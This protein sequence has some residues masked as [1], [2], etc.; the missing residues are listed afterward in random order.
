MLVVELLFVLNVLAANC[1]GGTRNSRA[2]GNQC[3]TIEGI[4]SPMECAEGH[5]LDEAANA[6]RAPPSFQC[7]VDK[8]V[9]IG[10]AQA[11]TQCKQGFAP[12]DGVCTA[13]GDDLVTKTAKCT[14][15]GGAAIEGTDTSCGKCGGDGYFL[16][17]GGCYK[18][19]ASPGELICTNAVGGVCAACK[20]DGSVFQNKASVKTPGSECILCSDSVGADSNKGVAN[21]AACDAPTG[22]TGTAKCKACAEGHALDEAANACRAPPSFQCEVD[23]LVTI[24]SAQACTQCKQ[25][26]APID[27]VCTA[28]GD[29]LVTKTAKCT[30]SGGAAIEGT[31][32]SCGKCGGDGYFLFMGGCYKT[33]ASPGELICTNAVG[34]VCAACKADGSVFQNKASV[35]TPG[36][37]CI[38]CSDSVG[39]DSNKG[40]A[41]CA[42]CDAPTGDTG[43]AKCKACAE[44]HALDEAA[45]ACRAP[46]S[47][48]CEVD[49][50]VTIGSAQACTQC[51]QGFAPIDG[52]CTAFGDDLVTKTAKCTQSGGAAIEGTDTSCGKCGGDGYFLFMGG[53]YKTGAS[54]GELICTNAVG[55]VCAACKAD[56]SVFQNKASVKTPGSECILCSD[57]VGADSNKGVANCAACDAPTGDTGT[58]KCKACAEGHALD[59]AA[60]ACVS[61]G[62]AGGSVNK[63]GLSTG[64][65]AGITVAVVVVVGGLAGFLCWWF[66]CRGKA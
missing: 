12:I 53:C 21:C 14:Q 61:S 17:M 9:T 51:K 23:K 24:G 37:E 52:V 32:T 8:L 45:N 30:Q 27:G 66:I 44:G 19:G 28:F 54:P 48:Q 59:E 18:T 13:F 65:I 16:F 5:A 31:D 46:P 42:A 3:G 50:L 26:F 55:G 63:G 60:N 43:T 36:S 22:D 7:E 2:T 56:G 57:S 39:A 1:A 40:V 34:G 35:K 10:S 15:S 11:C 64:A 49:K 47:F 20:A 25:G 6:C 58:A 29:D 38:L 62:G 4:S 41:N 33:G